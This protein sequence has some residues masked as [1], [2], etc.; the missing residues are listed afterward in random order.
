MIS[1]V[2]IV[3]GGFLLGFFG[4]AL[5]ITVL[6]EKKIFF[7][8][9]KEGTAE[10]VMRSGT[11]DRL[12]MVFKHHY[13]EKDHDVIDERGPPPKPNP[14]VKG[15]LY[16]LNPV[17]WMEPLGIY[18]IGIPPFYTI[19]RYPFVW[20]EEKVAE[21]GHIV[22]RLR[23]AIVGEE[24]LT[25]KIYIN[26]FNYYFTAIS[27]ES[28]DL[29]PVSF[30]FVVTIRI[31]NPYKALFSGKDWYQRTAGA[32][33]QMCISYAGKTAYKDMTAGKS[34]AVRMLAVDDPSNPP[35]RPLKELIG[36]LG[37]KRFGLADGEMNLHDKYGIKIVA[38]KIDSIALGDKPG[39]TEILDITLK[40]YKG[41]Q[42]GVAEAKKAKGEAEATLIRAEAEAQRI[43][44][45]YSPIAGEDMGERMKIRQLEAIEKND[46]KGGKTIVIPDKF[47]G[48]AETVKRI[49]NK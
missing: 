3:I 8:A 20:T 46:E 17:N 31:T 37:D 29:L 16:Y 30:V 14:E 44:K 2:A 33:S 25:S 24:G 19:H 32:I 9:P 27:V 43:E 6:A 41:E 45:V 5:F 38:V 22:P 12:L 21:G 40:G 15:L 28:F 35:L 18:W 7:T 42:E 47:L 39:S 23:Q 49:I 34:A 10:F 13:A 26:D 11:V 4:I 48:L 1:E 36:M